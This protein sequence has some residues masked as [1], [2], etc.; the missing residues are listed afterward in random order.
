MTRYSVNPRTNSG[1]G[2]LAETLCRLS[3]R[4]RCYSIL[5]SLYL[6]PFGEIDIVAQR[7]YVFAIV[8]V[9]ARST[10]DAALEPV[11]A[12]Q[13][14]RLSRAAQDFLTHHP[15]LSNHDIRFDIMAVKNNA[16]F[17]NLWPCH[18]VDAWRPNI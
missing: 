10:H 13:Q 7:K 15:Y 6:S 14:A 3:L 11:S 8:E 9:K 1:A 16:R 12:H 4:L 2:L 18:I 17:T 5:T